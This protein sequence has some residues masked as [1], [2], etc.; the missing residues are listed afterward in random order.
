MLIPPLKAIPLAGLVLL[1]AALPVAAEDGVFADKIIFG[2]AAALGGPAG[3]LGQGMKLGMEAAFAEAN[4]AGGI[5]GRKL[6]LKSVDDRYEPTQAIEVVKKLLADDKVFAIAGPVGTPTSMATL[7]IVSA[8]GAPFIGAFTGAEALREP[9]KPL[10]MNVRASYFEETEAMV[11]HLTNDLG[12]TRIAIMYQDDAFGQA[13]LAGVKR[14]LDKR[15]ME[16]AAEGTFERNTVA[17]KGALLAVRRAKPDA[18]IMIAP[19][20][21]AAQFIKLARQI[22]FDATCVNISFVGSDALAKELGDAGEGTVVTQVVPFPKDT[23]MPVVARYQAALKASA[24]DAQPGF[25]SL[26][27]YLV[28][29]AIVS[30]LEKIDGE[31]T[32]KAFV[33]AAQKS[34]GFD[35][36]GFRL[37]YGPS[38]NRGSNEVYLTEIEA[39]G[40]LK[41]VTSLAKARF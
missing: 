41:P 2:Q 39:D 35:L 3:A 31:P 29:R 9:Y 33:E 26:E 24:P 34:G 10:V 15:K 37:A 23:S 8:A 16:L 19:Y 1:A 22:K 4:K 18:V 17:V 6:E 11:A 25:V 14:A 32:R 13:G 28:G 12:A 21:P 5:K 7:P 20:K 30:V 38:N 40:T 27:G 36:G